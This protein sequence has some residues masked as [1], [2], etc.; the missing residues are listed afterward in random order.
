[1]LRVEERYVSGMP[2]TIIPGFAPGGVGWHWTAGGTGRSGWDATVRF[3]IDSRHTRNASYHGAFWHEHADEQTIIQWVVPTTRAAHSVNPAS[4]WQYNANKPRAIQDARFAEVR[5][6]LGAKASDPNA[7]MLAVAYPGMPA[8][9]QR[10]LECPVFRADVRNLAAQLVAH[11]A[12]VDRPHFGHGWIQPINRYE[13][14][15]ATDFIGLLYGA[16]LPDTATEPEDAMLYW[17]PVQEDWWTVAKTPTALGTTFYDANGTLKE[18]TSVERVRSTHESS[19]G[20][21]RL[22]KYGTESLVADA[23]GPNRVGPGLTPIAGTRVPSTG[24]GY[25]PPEVKEVPTGITLDDVKGAVSAALAAF[26]KNL[27]VWVAQRP[28]K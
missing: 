10:D 20:R 1:M 9:L 5:R 22:L 21:W 28:A 8:D 19:D 25:P 11:P 12:T 4:C 26:N 7:G 6:I 13:M 27:D 16:V 18:F 17:R 15:V 2:Q 3:L 14:D 23:R 24:Y